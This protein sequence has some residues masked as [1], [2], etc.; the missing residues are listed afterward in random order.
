MNVNGSNIDIGPL[1]EEAPGGVKEALDKVTHALALGEDGTP[2]SAA[3]M[4]AFMVELLTRRPLRRLAKQLLEQ[5]VLTLEGDEVEV[6][7]GEDEEA[8]AARGCATE[9]RAVLH[10][11]IPDH[12]A[13]V[14]APSVG[15][16][17]PPLAREVT[18][19]VS[20]VCALLNRS[21]TRAP[22]R[23]SPATRSRCAARPALRQIAEAPFKP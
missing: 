10:G 4:V 16:R 6:L 19:R 22:S 15:L 14:G 21:R 18:L 12:P 5:V 3:P 11:R 17:S 23:P 1:L 9:D 20:D 8:P 13:P 7:K 2:V